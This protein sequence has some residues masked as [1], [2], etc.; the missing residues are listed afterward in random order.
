MKVNI[1]NRCSDFKL[2]N[3]GYFSN[4]A[5]WN[6]DPDEEV[7]AGNMTSVDLLS[8]LPTFEGVL[9]YEL[10]KGDD[11]S[12]DQFESTHILFFV[13]WKAE[14]YKKF[15]MFVH[16]IEYDEY[17]DWDELKLREYYQR[18]ANQLCTYTGPIKNTWLIDDGTVLITRLKLDLTQRAGVLNVT[19]SEG[20][21]DS[22]T[23]KPLWVNP[24]R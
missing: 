12:D 16:L 13:A 8:S 23:E 6:G 21:R 1:Y 4:S 24:E 20:I 10:Q 18:Y 3:L 17:I 22:R 14:G 19:I 2:I 9:I 5:D 11:E 7:D 15:H